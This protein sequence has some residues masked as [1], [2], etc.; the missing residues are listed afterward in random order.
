MYT[1]GT[2]EECKIKVKQPSILVL[3]GAAP[4]FSNPLPLSYIM[5]WVIL[6][7]ARTTYW[8]GLLVVTPKVSQSLGLSQTRF[9]PALRSSIAISLCCL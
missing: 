4:S 9:G 7:S 1:R 6:Y 3:R 5:F 2:T 8:P